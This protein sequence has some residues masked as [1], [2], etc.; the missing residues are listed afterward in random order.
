[1]SDKR[2]FIILKIGFLWKGDPSNTS[3]VY[4]HDGYLVQI[5]NAKN[6]SECKINNKFVTPGIDSVS[7]ISN[8]RSL[9]AT[10]WLDSPFIQ[11]P[12]NDTL[13]VYQKQLEIKISGLTSHYTLKNYT[14]VKMAEL[15]NPLETS[16]DQQSN[17][18]IADNSPAHKVVYSI[19]KPGE[20]P[21]KK[22]ELWTIKNNKVYDVTYTALPNRY[23]DYLPTIQ[24]MIDS[25]KI[26]SVRLLALVFKV[27][28]I[29]INIEHRIF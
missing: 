11:P 22:M 13:D 17:S 27:M 12:L 25:F 2:L 26:G 21:L 6:I 24:K 29:L 20:I 18:T 1:M 3:P 10:V 8:G 28:L 15:Y 16:I 5:P 14:E 19:S 4:T 7:Y 9:N 23:A